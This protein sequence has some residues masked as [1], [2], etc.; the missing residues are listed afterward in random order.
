MNGKDIFVNAVERCVELPEAVR[1]AAKRSEIK[2]HSFDQSYIDFLDDQI[3]LNPRGPEWNQ[4][5]QRRRDGLRAFIGRQLLSSSL[6]VGTDGYTVE[7]D[8]EAGTVVYWEKY[9]AIRE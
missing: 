3:R 8:P 5:L 4:R 7:V 1:E 2:A 6:F 9:E